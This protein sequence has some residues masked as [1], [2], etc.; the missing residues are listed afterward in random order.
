MS[1]RLV[2]IQEHSKQRI[3]SQKFEGQLGAWS[4]LIDAFHFQ[5]E[6][7]LTKLGEVAILSS[8]QKPRESR[9]MKKQRKMSKPKNKI[10]VQNR[11]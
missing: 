4:G 3:N 5:H 9:K 1:T 7:I 8:E 2:N 10:N 11:S 6:T